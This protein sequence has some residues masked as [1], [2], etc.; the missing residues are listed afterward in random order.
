M[1]YCARSGLMWASVVLLCLGAIGCVAAT[2]PDLGPAIGAKTEH[3]A[4]IHTKLDAFLNY[5]FAGENHARDNVDWPITIIFWNGA[6]SI[7][8]IKELLSVGF[9]QTGSRAYAYLNNGAGWE[10]DGDRGRKQALCSFNAESA[11]YRVYAPSGQDYF[12]NT[13]WGYYAIASTHID[14]DEC[15]GTTNGGETWSG[16]SSRAEGWVDSEAEH[17]EL[18]HELPPGSVK[19]NVLELGNAETERFEGSHHWKNDGKASTIKIPAD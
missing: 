1:R 9:D 19:R 6:T 10:W 4:Q 15:G 18:A 5:D 13:A 8:K 2:D 16:L 3:L 11:H 17:R 7:D 14:H 12:F